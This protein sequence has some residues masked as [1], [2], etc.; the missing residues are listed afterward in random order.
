MKIIISYFISDFS[1]DDFIVEDDD[2][3]SES[4]DSGFHLRETH[5]LEKK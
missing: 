2:M 3:T 5:K 1:M 4:D